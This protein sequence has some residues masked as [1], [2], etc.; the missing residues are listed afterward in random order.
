MTVLDNVITIPDQ[1]TFWLMNMMKR[2][3]KHEKKVNLDG[4]YDVAI[5]KDEDVLR[6]F[7]DSVLGRSE[8]VAA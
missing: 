6:S 1:D 3:I 7:F 5:K 4:R 2:T 8:P